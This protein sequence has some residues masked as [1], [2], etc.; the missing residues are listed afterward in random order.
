[1]SSTSTSSP[2][3][4]L[5]VSPLQSQP[6]GFAGSSVRPFKPSSNFG[7]NLVDKLPTIQSEPT[8]PAITGTPAGP[9]LETSSSNGPPAPGFPYLSSLSLSPSLGGTGALNAGANQNQGLT[10]TSSP[11]LL[12]TSFTPGSNNSSGLGIGLSALG[13]GGLRPQPTGGA[14]NPFRASMMFG[15]SGIPGG[16]ANTSTTVAGGAFGGLGPAF[17]SLGSPSGVGAGAPG[18]NAALSAG[19]GPF[20]TQSGGSAFAGGSLRGT[21][22]S[23]QQSLI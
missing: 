6:T 19:F 8:T 15:G 2:P 17:P 16:A 4:Q 7:A 5:S 11:S 18:G 14:A 9:L 3:P 20:A 22:N 23:Q 12:A 21:N 1:M 10:Q 13:G